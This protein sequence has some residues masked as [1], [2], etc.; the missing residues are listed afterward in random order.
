MTTFIK[1]YRHTC[2]P[3]RI[4]GVTY[5][6]L[7]IV[8]VAKLSPNVSIIA[9]FESNCVHS[10][11]QLEREA[12]RLCRVL[13]KAAR[14]IREGDVPSGERPK[15][16]FADWHDVVLEIDEF[17]APT[18]TEI[19][20]DRTLLLDARVQVGKLDSASYKPLRDQFAVPPIVETV[21]NSILSLLVVP[22]A[23]IALDDW[24]VVK[25]YLSTR[26]SQLVVSID[27]TAADM[28]EPLM[29]LA[30]KIDHIAYTDVLK[31]KSPVVIVYYH[32]LRV[33]V[34]LAR[35]ALFH[36]KKRPRPRVRAMSNRSGP[37]ELPVPSSKNASPL[38]RASMVP[39]VSGEADAA[40]SFDRRT[41]G[42]EA[43]SPRSKLSQS[44]FS[45]QLETVADMPADAAAT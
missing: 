5:A 23:N 15:E 30:E 6:L 3:V 21:V 36:A 43:V 2:F 4:H 37:P 8:T 14:Y 10:S 41:S 40:S 1:P 35:L 32:W 29:K 38:K 11:L 34:S 25:Q 31:C 22:S 33:A 45:P 39:P 28:V 17:E 13:G 44:H 16:K 7:D 42:G 20:F 19:F 24:N 18:K 12:T 9:E 27:P 26:L